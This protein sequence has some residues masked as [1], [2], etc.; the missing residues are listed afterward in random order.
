MKQNFQVIKAL[1]NTPLF[2]FGDHASRYIPEKYNNLGLQVEDLDRHIAWDIGTETVV[3]ELC[4]AFGCSGQIAGVSRLVIDLNRHLTSPSLIPI[5]SDGTTIKRNMYLSE[6]ERKERIDNFYRPY[7]EG[8][9]GSLD[10]LEKPLVISIHSFTKKP[11]LGHLRTVDIGLLVKHDEQ[12]AKRFQTQLNL[13]GAHLSL[14][15]NEPYSAYDL[16]HTIDVNVAPRSLRHL[17]IEIRQ[18]HVDTD[19]KAILMANILANCIKPIMS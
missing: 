3:R 13:H 1:R 9:N 10:K 17:A 19:N 8:I 5:K 4:E 16:N 15:I 7:H 14:G 18:D 6:L 12:T 2:I 11:K